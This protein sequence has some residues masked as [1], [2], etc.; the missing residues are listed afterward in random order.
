MSSNPQRRWPRPISIVFA[1]CRTAASV[2]FN[3]FATS[4]TDV[5]A[6]EWALSCRMSSLVQGLRTGIFFF[7]IAFLPRGAEVRII[8]AGPE[9]FD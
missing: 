2:R 6:F 1:F 4:T 5:L 8:V 9:R 3:A 7:G